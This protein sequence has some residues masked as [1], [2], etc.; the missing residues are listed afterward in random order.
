MKKLAMLISIFA[1]FVTIGAV[2]CEAAAETNVIEISER[3]V[4]QSSVV[5]TD[6]QVKHKAPSAHP[7]EKISKK[8]P[9]N[10]CI[11]N[12]HSEYPAPAPAYV[13]VDS[14]VEAMGDNQSKC[15]EECNCNSA[16]TC[17]KNCTCSKKRRC[18]KDCDCNKISCKCEKNCKCKAGNC[19]CDKSVCKCQKCNPQPSPV[20][21]PVEYD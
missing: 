2:R 13:P 5:S 12:D 11:V 8:C 15:C 10:K 3:I 14:E 17:G 7:S 18:S 19:K 20:A 4:P 6:M 9:K 21:V 1:L 16:C